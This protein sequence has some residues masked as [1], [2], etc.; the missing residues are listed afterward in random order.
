MRLLLDS[1]VL[2]WLMG[3]DARLTAEARSLITGATAVF[4]S[5]ASFWELSIKASMGKLRL[6]IERLADLLDA[7]GIQE[8]QITRR[9]VLSVARLPLLH[10]DPFD[11]LLVAQANAEIMRLVTNDPKLAPYSDLVVMV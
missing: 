11:R 10:R 6:D 2:I 5:T 1:H 4:V 3:E 9:H 7:A 8:L